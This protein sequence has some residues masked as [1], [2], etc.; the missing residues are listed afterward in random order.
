MTV[1]PS[2]SYL[3]PSYLA[4]RARIERGETTCEAVVR[5]FLATI[6]AHNEHLN[7]LLAV[8]AE[9]ALRQ[10]RRLDDLQAAGT[11]LP[12]HGLVVAVKDVIC[13]EGQQTTCGSRMLADFTSLYDATAV[14]RLREAGAVLIG[15]ANCDEFA[16]GSSNENSHF[17]PVRNPVDPE[18]V[19]GGSSGGS[20]A[21]VAA[22]FCHVALGTDTGGSI[23]QPAAFCGVVGLKPTYGRVSRL[24][25]V[26]FAS[27]FDCLGP[28]AATVDECALVLAA[29]A[30]EDPWDATSAQRPVPDVEDLLSGTVEGLRVGLPKEYF[31][32]GLDAGVRQRVEEAA[33]RLEQAG[34]TLIEVSLPQTHSGI[35]TYYV[36]TM[37]EAS[38]NLA[39]YDGV[40]YGHR[41]DVATVRREWAEERAALQAAIDTAPDEA[42]REA[43]KRALG[44]LGTV[45]TRTYAQTR[46]EG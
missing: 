9:G 37:A 41:A 7:V 4:D 35:A 27:S 38:S 29:T 45:L 32:E 14:T 46:A 26:A 12:L 10:A 15:K 43:A 34:A 42:S 16:M 5:R 36:I 2:P 8:D 17:G 39:R 11:L 28:L 22:G 44:D 6:E 30:G 3:A 18:R 40:R 23:R 1:G 19:P 24:G 13:V 20:A 31:A 33:A 25:L 21:A